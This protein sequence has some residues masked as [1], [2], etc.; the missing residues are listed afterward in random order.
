MMLES[1]GLTVVSAADGHEALRLFNA[2]ADDS[3]SCCS[4]S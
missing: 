2:R 3:R 1:I 4:T